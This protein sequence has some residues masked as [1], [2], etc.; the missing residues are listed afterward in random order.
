MRTLS[1]WSG[2]APGLLL[3]GEAASP[4]GCESP[5]LCP[6]GP[7]PW[8]QARPECGL[9]RGAA[10]TAEALC[11]APINSTASQFTLR[12]SFPRAHLPGTRKSTHAELVA[13]ARP[14]TLFPSPPAAPFCHIRAQVS[15]REASDAHPACFGLPTSAA[16]LVSTPRC[17]HRCISLQHH[18]EPS[19]CQESTPV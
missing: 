5:L 17:G 4:A 3:S 8:A 16:V 1:C 13:L 10:S 15:P 14:G 18:R 2:P 9:G 7:P 12:S 19:E 11:T 6:A